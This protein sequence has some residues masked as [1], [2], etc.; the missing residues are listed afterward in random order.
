MNRIKRVKIDQSFFGSNHA[1][2]AETPDAPNNTS[3]AFNV[4]YRRSLMEKKNQTPS[5]H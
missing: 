3:I 1:M 5:A 2:I 4:I